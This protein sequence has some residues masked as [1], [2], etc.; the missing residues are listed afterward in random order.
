MLFYEKDSRNNPSVGERKQGA[1]FEGVGPFNKYGEY[2]S[3]IPSKSETLEYNLTAIKMSL[4]ES[5]RYFVA[6]DYIAGWFSSGNQFNV[7]ARFFDLV[8]ESCI[9]SSVST[10]AG[11]ISNNK[12]AINFHYFLNIANDSLSLFQFYEKSEIK[13]NIQKHRNWVK[14]IDIGWGYWKAYY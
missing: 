7:A 5:W 2:M 3:N 4:Q 11:L 6:V 14:R 12:G 8:S 10:L 1:E 9:R 13:V